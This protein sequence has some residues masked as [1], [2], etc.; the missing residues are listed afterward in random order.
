[1]PIGRKKIYV[2]NQSIN[3]VSLR[4]EQSKKEKSYGGY[5]HFRPRVQKAF[6]NRR[7]HGAHQVPSFSEEKLPNVLSKK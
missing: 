7:R 6:R 2:N 1:M 5:L 4:I 3:S